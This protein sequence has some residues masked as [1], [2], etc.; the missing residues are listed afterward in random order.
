M[1]KVHLMWLRNAD[2]THSFVAYENPD[3]A[4]AKIA[5]IARMAPGWKGESE[6]CEIPYMEDR[7]YMWR[8]GAR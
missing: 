1:K 2:G 3:D 5:D 6:V 8:P 7:W 4:R